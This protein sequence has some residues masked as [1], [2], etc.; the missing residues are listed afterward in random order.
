MIDENVIK[1]YKE[2]YKDDE[3]ALERLHRFL[4]TRKRYYE[5]EENLPEL[6]AEY[7]RARTDLYQTIKGDYYCHFYNEET[8]LYYCEG[9]KIP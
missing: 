7:R 8:F 9:F 3:E 5:D 4:N 2:F 6:R 1:K